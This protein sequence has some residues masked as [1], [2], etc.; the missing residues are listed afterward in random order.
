MEYIL[1]ICLYICQLFLSPQVT[2]GYTVYIL[3]Q[4]DVLGYKQA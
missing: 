3:N 4:C 2:L 1:Y